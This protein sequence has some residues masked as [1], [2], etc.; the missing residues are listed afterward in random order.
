MNI[1]ELLGILQAFTTQYSGNPEVIPLFEEIHHLGL[2]G[3]GVGGGSSVEHSGELG[4]LEYVKKKLSHLKSFTVFDVGANVGAYSLQ[5]R[6]LLGDDVEIY[7]FEP[8]LVTFQTLGDNLIGKKVH[9]HNFG[10][11]AESG[12]V[13]LFSDSANSGLASL[14]KRKLDHFNI[15]MNQT[16]QVYVRTIDDFCIEKNICKIGLLKVDV[17]G[18]EKEVFKGASRMLSDGAIYFIQFEFGGC[19]IDTKTFF[20]DFWYM[21]KDD[22]YFYRIVSGGL[23]P[24]NS[25]KEEYEC[26]ITTNYLLE[27]K[28]MDI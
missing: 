25:Y 8:S 13:T 23:F 1:N 7:A 3:M 10:L 12:T 20:Q 26:F 18:W 16:E 19:N 5:V 9:L 17:E 6:N 4:T 15:H 24:I 22:F 21:F 14:S 27:R 2:I 11:S 28:S